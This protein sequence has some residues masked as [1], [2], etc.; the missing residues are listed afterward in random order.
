MARVPWKDNLYRF[1]NEKNHVRRDG[2]LDAMI[3]R[4]HNKKKNK[5]AARDAAERAAWLAAGGKVKE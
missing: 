3:M 4:R 5:Q 1:G 2:T